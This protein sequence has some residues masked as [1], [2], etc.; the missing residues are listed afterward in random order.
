MIIWHFFILFFAYFL[1]LHNLFYIFSF[2]EIAWLVLCRM[3]VGSLM[4][5]LS[6][7]HFHLLAINTSFNVL[8]QQCKK[9]SFSRRIV[10]A[11]NTKLQCI[12]YNKTICFLIENNQYKLPYTTTTTIYIFGKQIHFSRESIQASIYYNNDIIYLARK[13]FS[14]GSLPITSSKILAHICWYLI[15]I[16][17]KNM[18]LLR[19]AAQINY[20]QNMKAKTFRGNLN[21]SLIPDN[22]FG[23]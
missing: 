7:L 9:I 11:I 22:I 14:Q 4:V 13:Y 10:L 23:I 20:L 5:N 3:K 15:T 8:Q 6:L 19:Q 18:L 12:H 21:I 1:Y 2:I 17:R 16:W